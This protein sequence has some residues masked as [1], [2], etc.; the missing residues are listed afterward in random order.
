MSLLIEVEPEP[1]P[2]RAPEDGALLID[3]RVLAFRAP[4]LLE[5]LNAVWAEGGTGMR[6]RGLRF[7]TSRQLLL[8]EMGAPGG[9][10]RS[11]RAAELLPLLIAWCI[12]ARIALP[13]Q[14]EKTVRITSG[15]AVLHCCVTHLA[16][17]RYRRRGPGG[18]RALAE[19][20][21]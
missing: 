6:A 16:V 1:V 19:W 10:E 4:A 18:P 21:R 17:P 11:L 5:I 15:G 2:P 9:D 8:V 13:S 7:I 14:A 12:G 3:R 20:E